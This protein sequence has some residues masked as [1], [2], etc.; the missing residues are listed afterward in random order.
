M[1]RAHM[2]R[3]G[4]RKNNR[5]TNKMTIR[6]P[7]QEQRESRQRCQ[8]IQV[9]NIPNDRIKGPSAE[10]YLVNNED[11]PSSG[12]YT[13][14]PR[15]D[16][17]SNEFLTINSAPSSLQL[18]V[19][20][21]ADSRAQA[22]TLEGSQTAEWA[23]TF[24][25]DASYAIY[26]QAIMSIFNFCLAYADDGN[27]LR[28]YEPRVHRDTL[29]AIFAQ[30]MQDGFAL[31]GQ[32]NRPE[33][34]R[35]QISHAF[36]ILKRCLDDPHPM[37]LAIIIGVLCDLATKRDIPDAQRQCIQ[38]GLLN[39]IAAYSP[40]LVTHPLR[41]FFGALVHSGKDTIELAL[42]GLHTVRDTL[43][44]LFGA[45]D[46][47]SLYVEERLCDSLYYSGIDGGRVE[48]RREL[49][50]KQEEVYGLG[51]R[52]V[53]WTL[54]NVAQDHL[55]NM[56]VDRAEELYKSALERAE[57]HKGFDRAKTRFAAFEGLADVYM[58]RAGTFHA[59]GSWLEY[60]SI[61]HADDERCGHLCT[62]KYYLEQ[63]ESE[64]SQWFDQTTSRR[65][66]RIQ[67][68]LR[69]FR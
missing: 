58:K 53:L 42:S 6:H 65:Y 13:H 44:G 50:R 51:A 46:W 64:A 54:T 5:N 60:V 22:P 2:N 62:A 15:S 59:S 38:Q 33:E 43:I 25:H 57:N 45:S 32:K 29:Q 28:H 19:V 1:I 27:H 26:D 9:E 31:L 40:L 67:D 11:S 20:H 30:G 10:S 24:F 21:D 55:L 23:P 36:N 7:T 8:P 12:V 16:S 52:N 69:A 56:Q 49:L 39:G 47:R 63:A 34:A 37:L 48:L 4:F 61:S 3:W 14:P 68:K 35:T 17:G 66:L 41:L 18:G